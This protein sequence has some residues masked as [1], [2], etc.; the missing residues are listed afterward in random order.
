MQQ[1][2]KQR[3]EV[4]GQSR[5]SG[6]SLRKGQSE[7]LFDDGPFQG[8]RLPEQRG[9][10]R[11]T[12]ED[13][14]FYQCRSYQLPEAAREWRFAKGIGRQWRFDFAF[15]EPYLVAVEIEGLVV[16]RVKVKGKMRTVSMGGHAMPAH[17]REDCVKYAQAAILG[18]TV[19]RFEQTQVTDKTAIEYT[20][21][22]LAAR[23]WSAQTAER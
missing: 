7:S 8:V 2:A 22:M 20:M 6:V 10:K 21:R 18:W 1:I 3:A 14:F 5:V 12:A 11:R 4:F 16:M 23:G 9:R 17:F 15:L 19:L 13:E